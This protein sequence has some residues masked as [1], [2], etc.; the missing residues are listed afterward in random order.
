MQRV[1]STLHEV[2][3]LFKKDQMIEVRDRKGVEEMLLD[4]KILGAFTIPVRRDGVQMSLHTYNTEELLKEVSMGVMEGF[5]VAEEIEGLLWLLGASVSEM[6]KKR[7]ENIYG[8]SVGET[9]DHFLTPKEIDAAEA[10]RERQKLV[11][12]L[13]LSGRSD[14]GSR[15]KRS[16]EPLER[17]ESTYAPRPAGHFPLYPS[18]PPAPPF[19]PQS[20]YRAGN[21]YTGGQ[22]RAGNPYGATYTGYQRGRSAIPYPTGQ[23]PV[24]TSAP[25][26]TV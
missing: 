6:A 18:Q 14:F 11:S 1:S 21:Q 23:T 15:V 12:G 20:P 17:E 25:T 5:A 4:A 13:D 26:G 19:F 8:K 10:A 9:G 3:D 22:Y 16:R 2:L 24:A 7:K